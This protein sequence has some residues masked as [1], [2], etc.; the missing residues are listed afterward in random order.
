MLDRLNEASSRRRVIVE[1][2][3]RRECLWLLFTHRFHHVPSPRDHRQWFF[4]YDAKYKWQ[5]EGLHDLT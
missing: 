5:V 2:L 4:D 3:S 1:Q